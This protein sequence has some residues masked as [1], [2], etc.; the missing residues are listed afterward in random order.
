MKSGVFSTS[1]RT[2][3]FREMNLVRVISFLKT[4]L[5]INLGVLA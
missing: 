3:T 2:V 4:Q 1:Q 5:L